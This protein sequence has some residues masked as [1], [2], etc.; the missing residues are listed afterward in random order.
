MDPASRQVELLESLVELV[1]EQLR[2]QRALSVGE[3]R[4][5]VEQVLDTQQL[6]EAF[7]LC[8]GDR[9][10]R[11]IAT[12]V[13]AGVATLSRWTNRWRQLGIAFENQHGRIQHLISLGALGLPLKPSA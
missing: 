10:L 13:G 4:A 11:E 6:R 8:D 2:W 1:Q 9:T 5:V 12:E 3:V 7:E